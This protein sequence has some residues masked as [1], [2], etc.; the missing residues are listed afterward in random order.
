VQVIHQQ[1]PVFQRR[2]ALTA[3]AATVLSALAVPQP[4]QAYLVDETAAQNVFLLTS[5][6][7]VS[8]NDFKQQNGA[9]VFEGVGT[10]IVWDKYGHGK[11]HGHM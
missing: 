4:C 9:E 7:V 2:F 6:S 3:A 5:R 11:R 8:I 10:G 1:P